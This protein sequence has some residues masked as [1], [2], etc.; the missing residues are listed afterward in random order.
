MSDRIKHVYGA[1]SVF[2]V[3]DGGDGGDSDGDGD[4]GSCYYDKNCLMSFNNL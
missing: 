1:T 4:D 2:V 3:D